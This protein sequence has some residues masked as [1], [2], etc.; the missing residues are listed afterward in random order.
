MLFYIAIAV[1]LVTRYLNNNILENPLYD[2]SI[3][4]Y[5]IAL[6]MTLI[7]LVLYFKAFNMKEYIK[8]EKEKLE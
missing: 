1:S 5:C 2:F 8:D 6:L 3:Y 7:A 4:L